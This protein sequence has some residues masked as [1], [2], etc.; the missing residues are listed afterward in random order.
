MVLGVKT[1]TPSFHGLL[2]NSHEEGYPSGNSVLLPPLDWPWFVEKGCEAV[3]GAQLRLCAGTVN[4]IAERLRGLRWFHLEATVSIK[5]VIAP[6][7]LRSRPVL[8]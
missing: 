3:R 6:R 8:K 1:I 7:G 2:H 5:L 4:P